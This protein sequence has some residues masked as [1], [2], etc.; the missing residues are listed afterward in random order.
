MPVIRTKFRLGKFLLRWLKV[1]GV[2]S[3]AL[4]AGLVLAYS[5]LPKPDLLPP[6]LEYSRTV[7]DREGQVIFLTTTSE[8]M[9]RLPVTMDQIAPEMLEATLEMEDRRFLSHHGVD[10]RSI[11]RAAWGV[12]SR[13]KLGGGSTITMQLSRLR[14]DLQTRS[15]VGKCEQTYRAIQLERHY[16][17]DQIAAAYFT[18]APYGGNVEG[19]RAASFRWCGKDASDL[20]LRESASLSAIPQSP[21]AR[22]PRADGNPSLAVAQTRLMTRLRANHGEAPNELDE[23]FNLVPTPIPREAPHL[24]RRRLMEEPESLTVATTLDMDQQHRVEKSIRDFLDRWH[25]QGLRNAS[26][27]LLHAPTGEIRASVG[28]ADFHN[29]WIAGQVD[30]TMARRSPG[31]TLKPFIYALALDAGL[32]HPH[33]LLDDAPRRFAG[34]NPENSD[35]QFLGPI[36]AG[37]ALRRSR[38]IPAIELANRLPDGGLEAFLRDSDV[39]LPKRSHGLALAIGA[40]EMRLEDLAK[41]YAQLA[42][43]GHGRLS[44]E[45]CWL[46]LDALRC[47]EPA[48]PPGLS[49]KTGTSNGFRDA[50]ACGVIGDWVLCVWVGHFSGR[51]MPGLFASETAAPLL[52]QTATRLDL[53]AP[54]KDSTRPEEV[55]KVPVCGV[56][57]D[58]A[59]KLCPN[60]RNTWFIGGV[61]PIISCKVHR[62][63]GDSV[64]EVWS[65]DRL[66]QFRKA[67]FP[68]AAAG[69]SDDES[70]TLR[71]TPMGPP[72]VILSP[73]SSLTY[74]IQ[75]NTDSQ[76][77]LMLEANATPG[78]RQ[79]HWFADR[80]YIGASA[81]AEPLPWEPAVGD[82]EVQAMDDAGRVSSRQVSVRLAIADR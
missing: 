16:S 31:S 71:R 65:A 79:I 39:E 23:F 32:I 35:R 74:Y 44:P 66:E 49:C 11:L 69:P 27:V 17:K 56:S 64:V 80:R 76:N 45:A 67:G 2:L 68:R 59:N 22:R 46:T 33:T 29:E 57:G 54:S 9:L 43:P 42:Y 77:R 6:D 72:P 30:G 36:A 70:D 63:S 40:T 82:Y 15:L 47:D 58:L 75:A 20:T 25:S 50:W 55:V 38:N 1:A 60:R 61:S 73:Q 24:A 10:P 19:V 7:L 13:Q 4:V 12:V 51:S 48:A 28:S 34:Y 21:T 78:T 14:W 37:E 5:L 81:P 26:A 52:W 3:V 62:M 41:L 53:H 8:G 18:L